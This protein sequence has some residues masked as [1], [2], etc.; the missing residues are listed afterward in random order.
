MNP[1]LTKSKACFHISYNQP[2]KMSVTNDVVEKLTHI[3]SEKNVPFSFLVSDLPVYI[4]I[5]TLKSEN[6][7]RYRDTIP[8]L[9]PFHTQ[10]VIMSAIYKRYAGSEIG[11]LVQAGLVAAGSVHQALKGSHYKRGLHCLRLL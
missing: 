8:F 1:E 2:P 9:G 4:L 7:D 11:V 10:C 3:I 6:T 5:T